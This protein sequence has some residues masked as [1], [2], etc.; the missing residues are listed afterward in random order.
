MVKASTV[1]EWG[2]TCI[3]IETTLKYPHEIEKLWCSLCKDYYLAGNNRL[4]Q[5]NGV[6]GAGLNKYIYGTSV[7]KKANVISHIASEMH[8]KAIFGI[9]MRTEESN[10]DGKRDGARDTVEQ[11]PTLHAFICKLNIGKSFIFLPLF[12][13]SIILSN[14]IIFIFTDEK[15]K[16]IKRF[17]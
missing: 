2:L 4:G 5:H 8:Q 15:D 14:K 7:I 6:V 11:Q 13:F 3:W 9:S 10:R 17:N 16:L 12:I 1:R